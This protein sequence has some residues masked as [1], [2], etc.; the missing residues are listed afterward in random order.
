MDIK[1]L[2]DTLSMLVGDTPVAEQID[3]ALNNMAKK[4]HAHEEYAMRKDL[5]ELKRKLDILISLVGD[6][7]V[8]EQIESALKNIKSV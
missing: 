6:T 4:D 2:S 3:Y 5:E 7:S 8:A 1:T